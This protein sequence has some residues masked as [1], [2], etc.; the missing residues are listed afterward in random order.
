[1]LADPAALRLKWPNDLLYGRAKLAGILLEGQG[2]WVV[3]GIG[4]NLSEAPELPDRETCAFASF[5][6]APDRDQFAEELAKTFALELDRW[7]T[8]GLDPVLRRWQAAALP[9]GTTLSIHD[10][11][12]Q[13]LKGAFAGLTPG[14]SLLLRLADGAT[15][16]VHAGDVTLAD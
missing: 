6:P 10:P 16:T 3:I 12:G 8:Y 15:H 11:D 5:G 14:G 2:E 13:L 9:P 7:R 4:V 1:M